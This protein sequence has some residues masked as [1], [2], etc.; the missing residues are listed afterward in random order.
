MQHIE[1]LKAR[2][3]YRRAGQEARLACEPRSYG[4]HYGMRS[5]LENAKA[6]FNTG[7][8]EI[9]TCLGTTFLDPREFGGYSRSK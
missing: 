2:G 7:Y 3:E 4:C 6:E 5:Q 8:D 1:Q 9:D